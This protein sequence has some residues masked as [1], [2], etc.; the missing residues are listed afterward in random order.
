MKFS[1]VRGTDDLA[2]LM[3][4][5]LASADIKRQVPLIRAE[6]LTVRAVLEADFDFLCQTNRILGGE[7]DGVKL[8]S[9]NPGV[10]D[11]PG[12][13]DPVCEVIA[14]FEGWRRQR[15]KEDIVEH[16]RL[17]NFREG[18]VIVIEGEQHVFRT[19][20]GSFP[21]VPGKMG[22]RQVFIA[23]GWGPTRGIFHCPKF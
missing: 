3:A 4:N 16:F 5:G 15:S 21:G 14:K 1:E 2:D 7:G 17:V 19:L 11:R 12:E 8:G 10:I 13:A 22:G 18:L 23:S 20:H 6:F 9:G